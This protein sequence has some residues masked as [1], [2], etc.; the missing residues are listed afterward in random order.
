MSIQ[1]PVSFL[2]LPLT[3]E[4]MP[5]VAY[6]QYISGKQWHDTTCFGRYCTTPNIPR[7]SSG[8]LIL[9]NPLV[10]KDVG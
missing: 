10:V 1:I 8:L 9:S 3:N 4:Y 7:L 2:Q 5:L 6:T